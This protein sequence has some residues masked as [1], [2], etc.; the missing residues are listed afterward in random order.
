MIDKPCPWCNTVQPARVV[1]VDDG[2]A[3]WECSV[4]GGRWTVKDGHPDARLLAVRGP[5]MAMIVLAVY[6]V[7][8]GRTEFHTTRQP[9]DG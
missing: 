1:R 4:C 7:N 2:C 9:G 5:M 6:A 8:R 3:E